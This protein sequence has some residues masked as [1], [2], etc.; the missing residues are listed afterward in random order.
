MMIIYISWLNVFHASKY[1]PGTS[2]RE[3]VEVE[4]SHILL[5]RHLYI[6]TPHPHQ[7]L[8]VNHFSGKYPWSVFMYEGLSAKFLE[9]TEQQG[10]CQ[11]KNWE[12]VQEMTN[13][14]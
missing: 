4:G 7:T 5:R 13:Y 8:S 9:I 12:S 6:E 1:V 3:E 2:M 10:V 14:F 11:P